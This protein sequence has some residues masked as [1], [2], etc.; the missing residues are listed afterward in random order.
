MKLIL[1][2]L[3]FFKVLSLYAIKPE[4][5]FIKE[6]ETIYSEIMLNID[7]ENSS[8]KIVVIISKRQLNNLKTIP[9]WS[10]DIL[11]VYFV[12]DNSSFW[13]LDNSRYYSMSLD[14]YEELKANIGSTQLGELKD[15]FFIKDF[16][17][18]GKDEIYFI[19]YIQEKQYLTGYEYNVDS[20]IK[21]IDVDINGYCK[22]NLIK[23]NEGF[24]N[25]IRGEEYKPLY[26][27]IRPGVFKSWRT[28]F[29]FNYESGIYE[30]VRTDEI[31]TPK[32]DFF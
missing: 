30:E 27:Q 15:F 14:I 4:Y 23:N 5:T 12:L 3:I 25:V 32:S 2:I 22:E 11:D 10:A 9:L 24:L 13:R 29:R 31:E 7:G 6:S 28:Y 18:N 20:Y 8:D 21:I 26:Q 17:N 1:F 16:N 19:E